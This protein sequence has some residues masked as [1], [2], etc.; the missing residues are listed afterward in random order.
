MK[1]D[2]HKIE[3][4]IIAATEG[5]RAL[6]RFFDRD[7]LLKYR[8]DIGTLHVNAESLR[9]ELGR[10]LPVLTAFLEQTK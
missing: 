5:L 8:D 1:Q 6:R 3:E 10:A 7:T 9:I 2:I 4:D